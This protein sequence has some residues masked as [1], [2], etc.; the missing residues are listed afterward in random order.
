VV[1]RHGGREKVLRDKLG[2]AS[3]TPV[4]GAAAESS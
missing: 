3:F 4:P 1:A 2:A